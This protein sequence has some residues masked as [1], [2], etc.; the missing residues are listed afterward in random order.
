[1]TAPYNT[2]ELPGTSPRKQALEIYRIHKRTQKYKQHN[3]H[4]EQTGK[5]PHRNASKYDRLLRV[6][7]TISDFDLGMNPLQHDFGSPKEHPG[8][9]APQPV[10]YFIIE[11]LRVTH[12]IGI[13]QIVADVL[14]PIVHRR[15]VK[16]NLARCLLPAQHPKR[17]DQIQQD[18]T[19]PISRQSNEQEKHPVF[20]IHIKFPNAANIDVIPTMI[21]QANSIQTMNTEWWLIC[22]RETLI[23]KAHW[24]SVRTQ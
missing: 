12:T 21:L 22:N 3:R 8:K 19:P 14:N 1:M 15:G 18:S 9:P 6:I 20:E 11:V 4:S 23:A 24:N 17:F 7:R 16:Q 2:H 10:A 13:M 5:Q